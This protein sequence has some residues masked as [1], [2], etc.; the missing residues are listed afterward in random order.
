MSNDYEIQGTFVCSFRA[1]TPTEA[2]EKLAKLFQYAGID[3]HTITA[4]V[5]PSKAEEE[6]DEDGSEFEGE[7]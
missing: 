1:D 4:V 5:K 3:K 7:D 6:S 2:R